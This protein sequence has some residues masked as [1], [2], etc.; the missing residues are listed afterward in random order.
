MI[1]PK[2]K[3]RPQRRRT[4]VTPRRVNHSVLSSTL[5]IATVIGLLILALP[6]AMVLFVGFLPSLVAWAVD[7]TKGHYAS[8]TVVG[9]N[10]AGV[11]PFILKLWTGQNDIAAAGRLIT[12]PFTLLVM[13]SAAGVGWLMFLGFPGIIAGLC[14]MNANRRIT[15]LKEHQK[16]LVE[17]W[18]TAITSQ[19][20]QDG[21]PSETSLSEPSAARQ[22][23]AA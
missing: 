9:V 14:T 3:L 22:E 10:F 7:D 4:G 17:E 12:D 6:T 2:R 8:R 16:T 20:R 18:G 15:F 11:A 23:H 5:T 21:R 1:R 13:F 19:D